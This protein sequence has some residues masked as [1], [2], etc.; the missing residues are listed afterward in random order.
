MGPRMLPFVTLLL[1]ILWPTMPADATEPAAADSATEAPYLV[2][3]GIAQDGGVPQ[4]GSP[5]PDG[6]RRL[7]TCLA[8]VDPSNGDRV[9]FEATPDLR[10]QL[11]TLDRLAP[12]ERPAPGLAGVFLTHAH[13]GH[14]VGLMFFGHE[15]IG[16]RDVP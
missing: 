10:E 6:L 9:L 15:S 13:I 2:V 4:A 16:A 5:R 8:A 14:Y 1:S 3:L 7:V 12:V 11:D